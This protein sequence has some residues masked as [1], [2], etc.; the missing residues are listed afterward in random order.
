MS[1]E[2]GNARDE[3]VAGSVTEPTSVQSIEW[4][5]DQA[6]RIAHH[7]DGIIHE[8]AAIVWGANTLLLGFILEVPCESNNQKLVVVVSI[9]GLLMS[10]YVPLVHILVKRGQKIAYETCQDIEKDL[11]FKYKLHTAI[12][13]A[14]PKWKPGW[15]AVLVLT[16]VFV[17]TWGY[18]TCHAVDCLIR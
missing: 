8:V 12:D 6:L 1:S 4:Q 17:F 13:A 11:S 14:Y 9:V 7:S 18:V 10:L 3:S 15:V 5:Y 16:V 2:Q